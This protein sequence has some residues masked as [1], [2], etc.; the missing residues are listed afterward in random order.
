MPESKGSGAARPRTST[1][2]PVEPTPPL[3]EIIRRIKEKGPIPF[4]E[5]METAL[6]W[7]EGGYYTRGTGVWG[8]K[9]DYITSLDMG[10]LFARTLAR[11][12]S[13]MW[14]VCGSP[15]EFT[16]VEAGAGRGWLS[17]EILSCVRDKYPGFY[18]ALRV[19]LVERNLN[20]H[21]PRTDKVSWRSSLEEVPKVLAGCILSNE[22]IDSFPV[23]RVEFS[24]GELKEVYTAID[25]SMLTD[26]PGP[27]S[28]ERIREYFNEAGVTMTEGQIT[29]ANL[30]A[31]DWIK[32]AG[33]LLEKGFVVTIDYGLPA[34][35]LYAPERRGTLLCHYRHKLNDNPY[36]NVGEQDI[37]T[38]VDFSSL[39]TEGRKA[40]LELTGFTTQKNFLLGAGIL[41]ELQDLSSE[42]TEHE[43]ITQGQ[44]VKE[45]V[46][47][48][49]M[50]DT[51][52]VLVQHKGL[53][54][55]P[56]LSCFSFRD[57]SSYL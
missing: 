35:E 18:S 2:V 26:F 56:V 15:N 27:L 4:S 3:K 28:S 5:F 46:M 49:G 11:E 30:E 51:F 57:M 53:P 37:T 8:G 36:L 24:E 1:P 7:N 10:P 44:A 38:H 16:L 14:R 31:L 32:K 9:G 21:E 6:Y 22:L 20:L 55:K 45:L 52:K 19:R 34:R 17:K 43:R 50:G 12:L 42:A 13:E 29:E 41:D 47:P 40:G 23:H 39:V 33:A 25:D 48:G 54:E